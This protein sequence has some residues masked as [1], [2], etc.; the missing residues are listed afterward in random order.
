M[1]KEKEVKPILVIRLNLRDLRASDDGG[2]KKIEQ[3]IIKKL[4]NEYHVLFIINESYE[5]PNL[6]VLNFKNLVDL[7]ELKTILMDALKTT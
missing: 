2:F 6:E 5:E 7:D 3:D 1:A 4:N